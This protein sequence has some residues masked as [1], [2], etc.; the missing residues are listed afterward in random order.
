MGKAGHNCKNI[1]YF[2]QDNVDVEVLQDEQQQIYMK[3]FVHEFKL[4]LMTTLV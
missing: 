2:I 1:W 3:L 4:H